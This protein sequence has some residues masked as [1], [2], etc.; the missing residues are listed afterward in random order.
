MGGQA[1]HARQ[2]G[3]VGQ[4]SRTDQPSQDEPGQARDPRKKPRPGRAAVQGM[5][6]TIRPATIGDLDEII[7]DVQRAA[8]RGTT[9]QF[10]ERTAE[11][12]ADELRHVVVAR[13]GDRCVGWAATQLF[14][15]PDGLA[16]AGHYLMGVTV[17]PSHRRAGIGQALIA[18]RIAWILER[19]DTVSYFANA[20][21][22]ASLAAHHDWPFE[23]IARGPVFHGVTFTG[24]VGVLLT[25]R[26]DCSGHDAAHGTTPF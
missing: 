23:E 24:G 20:T 4:A 16:P 9:T 12:I 11:A 5:P 17:E 25:A 19:D 26:F 6:L 8:G 18:A 14:A 1:D 3:E 15:E 21:N 22:T 2:A 10:R 7:N 13:L